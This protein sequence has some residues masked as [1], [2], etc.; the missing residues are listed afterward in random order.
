MS[1]IAKALYTARVETTG[2][3]ENGLS[4]SSDGL[5]DVRLST[6]GTA[7]IGTN[8]EQLFAAS[9]SASLLSAI[10]SAARKRKIALPRAASVEIEIDLSIREGC[11]SIGARVKVKLPSLEPEVV[12]VLVD[13]AQQIC[14]YARATRGNIDVSI[15]FV[16]PAGG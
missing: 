15:E 7:R 11:Y 8:P 5:L 4:R 12:K 6:P 2:G 13:E 1:Q 3:R 9:W 16:R 10:A 14:P